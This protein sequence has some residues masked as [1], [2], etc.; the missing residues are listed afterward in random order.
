MTKLDT[1]TKEAIEKM[2]AEKKFDVVEPL[3]I[4][5]SNI[6]DSI[7]EKDYTK[8]VLYIH[9]AL[10]PLYDRWDEMADPTGHIDPVQRRIHMFTEEA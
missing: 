7:I 9:S 4:L 8:A 6:Q 2:V 5:L 10:V 1:Q 3:A